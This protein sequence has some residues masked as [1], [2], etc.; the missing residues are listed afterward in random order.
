MKAKLLTGDILDFKVMTMEGFNICVISETYNKYV[1]DERIF[2]MT[3]LYPEN[4]TI[5]KFLSYQDREAFEEE[6][7]NYLDSSRDAQMCIAAIMY[8]LGKK[9]K[10]AIINFIKSLADRQIF[11]DEISENSIAFIP[12]TEALG[13]Y[14]SMRFDI[15]IVHMNTYIQKYVNRENPQLFEDGEIGNKEEYIKLMDEFKDYFDI[16]EDDYFKTEDDEDDNY[17]MKE[18]SISRYISA[19]LSN[20]RKTTE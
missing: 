8:G 10:M 19:K 20:N 11:K 2:I 14:L 6:Y 5:E 12:I 3:G 7:F 9:R 16:T 4:V 18:S 1:E 13:K 15:E 17:K